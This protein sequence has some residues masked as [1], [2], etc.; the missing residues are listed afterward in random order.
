[1]LCPAHSKATPLIRIAYLH[2]DMNQA[3]AEVAALDA[4]F[5]RVVPSGIV[6]LDDYEWSF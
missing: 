6:I 5:D 4:L 3:P 1:V 2:I